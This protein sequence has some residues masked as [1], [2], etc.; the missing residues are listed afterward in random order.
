M[1]FVLVRSSR[2]SVWQAEPS[3]SSPAKHAA[4]ARGHNGVVY[5]D[6]DR[7]HPLIPEGL[8]ALRRK[9]IRRVA[10]P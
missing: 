2:R 3:N 7:N 9:L 10:V 8:H 4:I 6:G 1:V 5:A